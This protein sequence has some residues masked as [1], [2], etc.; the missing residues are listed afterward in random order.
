MPERAQITRQP[1]SGQGLVL[2]V[3]QGV[4]CGPLTRHWGKLWVIRATLGVGAASFL[5]IMLAESFFWLLVTTGFF[6]LATSLLMPAL[7]ALTSRW[8]AM[9]QG[10]T[11]GLSNSAMSLGRIAGPLWGGFSFGLD[12]SYP[13]WSG[14]A[15]LLAGLGV[16][17][18]R[19][20]GERI[21]ES[22]ATLEVAE[23]DSL[24]FVDDKVNPLVKTTDR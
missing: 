20:S 3:A 19:P 1:A 16:S 15:I 8:T 23:G 13:F 7:T 12:I 24:G 6:F 10:L 21:L 14:T 2:A 4:L 18:V 17:L 11:M 9:E 5:L 22:D